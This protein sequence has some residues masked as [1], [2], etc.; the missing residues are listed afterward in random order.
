MSDNFLGEIR[1]M[2]FVFP[3]RGWALCNGQ[4]LAINQF[5]ALFSLLGTTYG[6]DGRTTFALP[7]LRDR[8]PI[9]VHPGDHPQGNV[10]GEPAHALVE[11]ELPLHVHMLMA[12]GQT[13]ADQNTNVAGGG[14]VL[15][16]SGGHNHDDTVKLNA[17]MYGSGD[18]KGSLNRASIAVV[19]Q[20]LPH[21]NMMP[22]LTLSFCIATAGVFPSRN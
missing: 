20:S 2:S 19:G 16:Q 3:P 22:Y 13:P 4:L 1:I 6:G 11:S 17:T 12:D 18:P 9:H 7:D 5:Q 21:S 15:G 10:G 14:V 8:V